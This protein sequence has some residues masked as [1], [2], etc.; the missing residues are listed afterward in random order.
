MSTR[1]RCRGPPPSI[2]S[3]VANSASW[4]G[5]ATFLD[6]GE[7]S[8]GSREGAIAGLLTLTPKPQHKA[9]RDRRNTRVD[10][11]GAGRA[12]DIY[13]VAAGAQTLDSAPGPSRA[14]WLA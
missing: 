1:S 12:V 3:W 9:A 7:A 2:A 8:C 11:V 5:P 13:Y 6:R 4:R 10:V 14:R